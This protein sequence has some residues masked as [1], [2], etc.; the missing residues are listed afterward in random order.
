M[1][2]FQDILI[3]LSFLLEVAVL[4]Y[5]EMKAWRT[6]YTP[7]VFLMLPY[8]IILII[9]IAISGNFGFVDFYY[10]SILIWSVGLLL[11]TLPSYA[12]SYVLQKHNRPLNSSMAE[13]EMP[14]LIV[15]I[16]IFLIL[17]FVWRFRSVNGAFPIGSRDFGDA[18]CGKGIWGHLRQL[19]LPILM[20]SIYFVDRQRWWL[21]LIIIP[22]LIIAVL[23]QILG[24][25]IIP[26]LVGIMLRLYTG[27][28]KLKLSLMIYVVVGVA[29]VFLGSYI[30]SL[31]LVEENDLD[32]E[33][34]SFIFRNFIHYLTSGTLGLSVDMELGYP[35]E[36]DFEMLITQMVNLGNIII[37][38]DEIVVPLNP[39]YYNT[40]FNYTNVRTFFGTIII[41]SNYVGFS[42]YVLF[43]SSCIYLL[44]LATIKYNNIFVYTIYFFECGLLFMGWFDSY[45]ASLSVIEIPILSLVLMLLCKICEPKQTETILMQ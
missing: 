5:L 29:I 36:G 10:P 1:G 2:G 45:F 4:F 35:D 33:V 7:L 21:W 44:K 12:L 28:T 42:V 22:I 14:K 13:A 43:I 27:K 23:Y 16:A 32:N 17:L 6:L 40:G 31:V 15:Y 18:L 37:G 39:F 20:M 11:F 3:L 41:N 9:S 38:N 25:L 24:W 19:S 26:C 34:L 30:I 8:T